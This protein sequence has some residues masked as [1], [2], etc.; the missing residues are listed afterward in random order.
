MEEWVKI[1]GFEYSINIKG[2][3]INDK[4]ERI[5]KSYLDSHGYYIVTLYKNN[6]EKKY[7]IHRLIGKYFIENPNNYLE[8]DHKNGNRADNTI[9][10]L[11]WCNSSQNKRNM[12]KRENTTSRFKGISFC[13][14]DNK[15][16]A[17]C[18]LNG[19][20]KHIGYYNTEIEGAEAYNNFVREN[21]LDDF[22]VLN[23][24][25]RHIP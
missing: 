17:Q 20:V 10:N 4:T 21:N 14:R 24:L 16:R 13:K 1:E 23:V 22:A 11:R 7:K 9:E 18:K 25:Q 15:W 19:K 8:I 5:M 3:V 2:E 6:K 12:K